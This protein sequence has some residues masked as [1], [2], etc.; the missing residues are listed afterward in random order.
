ML[1]NRRLLLQAFLLVLA[2]VAAGMG[3]TAHGPVEGGT[4]K[5]NCR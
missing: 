1:V 4:I 3:L 2:V 5:T